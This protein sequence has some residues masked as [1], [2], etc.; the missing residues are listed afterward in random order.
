MSTCFVHPHEAYIVYLDHGIVTGGVHNFGATLHHNV[1]PEQLVPAPN[2]LRTVELPPEWQNMTR[3]TLQNGN[4]TYLP[5]LPASL[6]RITVQRNKLVELPTLPMGVRI[7]QVSENNLTQLPSLSP[8]L[9]ELHASKNQLTSIPSLRG[10]HVT[11]LGV[12]KNELAALPELP[13]TIRKI[14][15]SFNQITEIKNLPANIETLVCNNNPLRRLEIG[16]LRALTTLV[17][18]NCELTE[19]PVLPPPQEGVNQIYYF[20]NNPLTPEFATIYETY[21]A[22]KANDANEENNANEENE[23]AGGARKENTVRKFRMAINAIYMKRKEESLKA[24]QLVFK[25]PMTNVTGQTTAVESAMSGNYGPAN[26][27][28]QFL[29]GKTGTLEQQKLKLLQ[30]KED[31]GLVPAGT[32]ATARAWI[33][34]VAQSKGPMAS[35]AKRYLTGKGGKSRSITHRKR[36]VSHGTRKQT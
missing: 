18:N 21:K 28:A 22:D 34:S 33:A 26:I 30:E 8:T 24:I 15:C 35:K 29:S 7:L 11:S 2:D 31:L 27:V 6:E 4:T 20:D 16:N 25:A 19:L 14:G 10:T 13:E 9:E 5:T 36:R 3:L 17:A 1:T 32:T 23:W 12:S